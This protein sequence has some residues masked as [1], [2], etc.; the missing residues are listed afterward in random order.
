LD[1]KR[2]AVTKGLIAKRAR[3][4]FDLLL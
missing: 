2:F 1:A 3:G 4:S